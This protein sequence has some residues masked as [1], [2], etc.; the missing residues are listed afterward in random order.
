M[1]SS[2]R[3]KELEQAAW[4]REAKIELLEK[5]RQ[6][7]EDDVLAAMGELR[8]RIKHLQLLGP[9]SRN[10]NGSSG[11]QVNQCTVTEYMP[12]IS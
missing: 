11:T 3:I 7:R 4:A 10:R 1:A 9:T 8:A 6:A 5:Q 12:M 2:A